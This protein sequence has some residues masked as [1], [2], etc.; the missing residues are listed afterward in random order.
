MVLNGAEMEIKKL[1]L[2]SITLCTNAEVMGL[3][4]DVTALLTVRV[5]YANVAFSAVAER[6]GE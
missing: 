1:K 6:G 2:V 5:P 3:S 4:A